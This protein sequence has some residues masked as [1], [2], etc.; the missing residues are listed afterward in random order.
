MEDFNT[1]PITEETEKFNFNQPKCPKFQSPNLNFTC[2][3]YDKKT[4]RTMITTTTTGTTS[5]QSTTTTTTAKIEA[6]TETTTS[7]TTSE[8]ESGQVEFKI[9]HRQI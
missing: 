7:E 5:T 9:H 4:V 6:T 1:E 3:E 2:F 8:T